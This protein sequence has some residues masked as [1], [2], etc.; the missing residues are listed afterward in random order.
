MNDET[1]MLY[2]FNDGLSQQERRNVEEALAHD[3]SLRKQYEE[4]CTTLDAVDDAG[5]PP[6]PPHFV[7]QLH[8]SV[9]RA[10]T[11]ERQR[12]PTPKSASPYSGLAWGALVAAALA[13]GIGIGVFMGE[14]E[15]ALVPDGM[16]NTSPATQPP[17][18]SFE[19]SLQVHLR[20]SREDLSGE[21]DT[22]QRTALAEQIIRQN[23]LFERA[24]EQNDA[25]DLARV[26]RAFEPILQRLAANDISPAEA[27]RLQMQLTFELNVMLT[28]LGRKDSVE[29]GPI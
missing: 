12:R 23:R 2:Y 3:A 13:L 29:T 6:A 4:M 19:R 18:L 22:T 24:A 20:N 5:A 11:L 9:S 16:V 17:S 7:A 27:Q 15:P 10:A 14:T 21:P 26:L 28:K 8:E 25:N 1:L